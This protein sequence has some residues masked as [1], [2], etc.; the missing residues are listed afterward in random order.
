MHVVAVFLIVLLP[1]IGGILGLGWWDTR[2]AWKHNPPPVQ[3]AGLS[4][5]DGCDV[6]SH[7]RPS[8]L[9]VAR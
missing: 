4:I 1:A 8:R 2:L 7:R 9:A 3:D 6:R 5:L